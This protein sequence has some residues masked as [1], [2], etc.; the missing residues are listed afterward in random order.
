MV[1]LATS[2]LGLDKENEL[3]AGLCGAWNRL[4]VVFVRLAGKEEFKLA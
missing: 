4:A 1:L 2:A 3:S